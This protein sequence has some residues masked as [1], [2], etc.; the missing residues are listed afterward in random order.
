MCQVSLC[1][2][3]WFCV[4]LFYV[5]VVCHVHS[6]VHV[7]RSVHVIKYV[8]DLVALRF[9]VEIIIYVEEL[10]FNGIKTNDYV[11]YVQFNWVLMCVLPYE[12][13]VHYAK[14]MPIWYVELVTIFHVMTVSMSKP[15]RDPVLN[16]IDIYVY[17][18]WPR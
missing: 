13:I 1:G 12:K 5:Y 14:S 15:K 11:F 18:E 16:V 9:L 7:S 2:K 8:G 6:N 17:V 4:T 3:R 10:P